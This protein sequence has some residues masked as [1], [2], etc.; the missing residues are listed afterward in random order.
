[1]TQGSPLSPALNGYGITPLNLDAELDEIDLSPAPMTIGGRTYLVRRDLTGDE[2]R[3]YWELVRVPDDR[4]AFSILV[5]AEEGAILYAVLESMP[6]ARFDLAA[7]RIMQAAG[8]MAAD[9]QPGESKA[10]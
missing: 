1:M 9:D 4:A 10:S 5:G 2:I 7:K 6:K 8:L 3:N